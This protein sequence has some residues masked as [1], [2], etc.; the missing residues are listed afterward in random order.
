MAPL[1]F[2]RLSGIAYRDIRTIDVTLILMSL[3]QASMSTLVASPIAPPTPTAILLIVDRLTN[4]KL[5]RT[6]IHQDMNS[7]EELHCPFDGL[8]A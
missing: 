2:F 1:P 4:L 8:F 3:S 6:N 7:T 5:I